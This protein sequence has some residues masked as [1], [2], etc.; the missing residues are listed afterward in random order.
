MK[1]TAP[2]TLPTP[3]YW[4]RA[5]DVVRHALAAYYAAC[6]NHDRWAAENPGDAIADAATGDPGAR[7]FAEN[8]GELL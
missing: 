4:L 3:Y 7:G 2:Q 8:V 5:E 6:R 1:Q